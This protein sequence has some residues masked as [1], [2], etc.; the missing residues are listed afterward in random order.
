[1]ACTRGFLSGN[2]TEDSWKNA[3]ATEIKTFENCNLQKNLLQMFEMARIRL[4][5]LIPQIDEEKLKLRLS[6]RS[7]SIGWLLRHIAEVE[8]LFAKNVFELPIK[9]NVQTIESE[10][11]KGNFK[12]FQELKDLLR[13]SEA[14]LTAAIKQYNGEDWSQNVTTKEFGTVTRAEALSRIISHT[15]YHSG[16]IAVCLKYGY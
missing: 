11:D 14:N 3:K 10:V 13:H 4:T 1:M 5:N 12:N 6:E 9:V 16:Q 8:L 15:A 2:E 7:N